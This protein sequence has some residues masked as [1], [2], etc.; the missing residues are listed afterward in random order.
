MH[1]NRQYWGTTPPGTVTVTGTV[2]TSTDGAL[3]AAAAAGSA[4]TLCWSPTATATSGPACGAV[5]LAAF[6][7][8]RWANSLTTL[9]PNP[10]PAPIA[11]I[12]CPPAPTGPASCTVRI[13]WNEQ[14]VAINAQQAAAAAQCQAQAA[15]N[16]QCFEIPTYTLYVEP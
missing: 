11:T 16:A 10:A 6:D 12:S 15:L 2:V 1:S 3:Q 8:V 7:L 4:G 13:S 14:A 5:Q 9:L